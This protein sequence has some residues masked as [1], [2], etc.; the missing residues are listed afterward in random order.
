MYEFNIEI[1][2]IPVKII[3]KH[4]YV[5][6]LCYNYLTEKNP[7]FSVSLSNEDILR[8]VAILE[9]SGKRPLEEMYLESTAIY[10]KI[11]KELIKYDAFMMHSAAIKLHE[12][13][14]AF[15]GKSGAGKTTQSMFWTKEFGAKYINGDK[16]IIRFTDGKFYVFGT[17]WS[18]K[19]RLNTN[20]YAELKSLVLVQKS[21]S[22]KIE[23][24]SSYEA[25][26]I[27][28]NQINFW[29]DEQSV[30]VIMDMVDKLL[31]NAS[32]YRLFCKKEPESAHLAY[33]YIMKSQE[34]NK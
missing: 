11:L 34:E 23:R 4:K 10:R 24:L 22:N 31:C 16:P 25:L 21:D 27:V 14:V 6:E 17:P 7:F 3:S 2:T 20:T 1:A 29:N 19:E 32:V 5:Y 26:P 18:G 28:L 13:A 8:E 9:K 15:I 30:S 33:N 12:T